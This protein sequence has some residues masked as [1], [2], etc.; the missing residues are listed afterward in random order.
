MS[1]DIEIDIPGI[2]QWTSDFVFGFE[3][4][5]RSR[6]RNQM[7]V[8]LVIVHREQK[9]VAGVGEQPDVAGFGP[10]FNVTHGRQ[11]DAGV[12]DNAASRLQQNRHAI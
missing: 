4:L 11:D 8:P 9:V 10:A 12:S 5:A 6:S 3:R 2:A 7:V 1:F